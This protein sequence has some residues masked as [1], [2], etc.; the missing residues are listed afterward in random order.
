MHFQVV[1][2]SKSAKE[3]TDRIDKF[4]RE[5]RLK[6]KDMPAD[7]FMEHLAALA[8]QKLEMFNSLSEETDH[9]WSE[10]RDGRY[11]FEVDRDD[12]LCLRNIT[13]EQALEAYDKWLY[14]ESKR[15]MM[16]V[17]VISGCEGPASDGRPEVDPEEVGAFIDSCVKNYHKSCKNQTWGKIY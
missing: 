7:T 2:S 12:V 14:P 15:R 3:A 8:K 16:V 9:L 10:I 4:L 1:T 17:Q 6:L 11:F 13:K 5:Y